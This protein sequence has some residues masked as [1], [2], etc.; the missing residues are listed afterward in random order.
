M[1]KIFL[2][3]ILFLSANCFAKEEYK[4]VA[5]IWEEKITIS[6][7]VV[8]RI[9]F[10]DKKQCEAEIQ[11]IIDMNLKISKINQKFSCSPVFV[12]N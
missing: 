6:E 7:P 12:G 4:Y 1:K 10:K 3:T 9:L 8:F 11:K 5:M 2:L